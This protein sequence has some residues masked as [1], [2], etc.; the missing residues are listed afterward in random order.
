MQRIWRDIEWAGYWN[1]FVNIL[2]VIFGIVAWRCFWI[3]CDVQEEE[4]NRKQLAIKLASKATAKVAAKVVAQATLKNGKAPRRPPPP[5]P[6]P[7]PNPPPPR[8]DFLTPLSTAFP[9][10]LV[11]DDLCC[12]I[13]LSLFEDPV[14]L[15]DGHVYSRAAIEDRLGRGNTTS[16][17]SG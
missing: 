11:H 12:S 16:P 13:T 8:L 4:D 5:S 14:V 1:L 2:G 3:F 7:T 9:P 10:R 6:L 17:K 15:S